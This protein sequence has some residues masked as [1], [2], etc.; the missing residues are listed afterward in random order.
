[1][2]ST[3]SRARQDE[4]GR[5]D[6]LQQ[7]LAARDE[8]ITVSAHELRTPLTALRMQLES[9]A[10]NDGD[11]RDAATKRITTKL[12]TALRQVDRMTRLID[13]L[14]DASQIAMSG[15]QL[16][17]ADVDL[18]VLVRTVVDR[19]RDDAR[20][21]KSSIDVTAAPVHGEWDAAR[22]EQV[23]AGVLANAI[24]YAPG[25]IIHVTVDADEERARIII[26]DTGLGIPPDA[27]DRVFER[28]ERAVS[29]DSYGGFGI[30][31]Y[32]ARQVIEAHGGTIRASATADTGGTTIVMTLPLRR[33]TNAS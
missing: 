10:M 22:L 3:V 19:L 16:T 17:P 24:K 4:R 14:L 23:I 30:G 12:G 26:R 1:M 29:T 7:S 31:L 11:Q 5:I 6:A 9:L 25:T 18:D 15:L 2:R 13:V 28:F 8:F 32:L 27:L 33:K 20:A 21:S